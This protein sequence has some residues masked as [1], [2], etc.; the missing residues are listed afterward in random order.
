MGEETNEAVQ[1]DESIPV[2]PSQTFFDNIM[3]EKSEGEAEGSEGE[4]GATDQSTTTTP[5][6]FTLKHKRFENGERNFTKDQYNGYAQKGLDY[7]LKMH[8]IKGERKDLETKKT[9]IETKQKELADSYGEY[10][11]IDQYVRDNPDFQA[12]ITREWAKIQGQQTAL[13]PHEQKMQDTITALENRINERDK[14]E[15]DG[16]ESRATESLINSIQSFKEKNASF[17]W[18]AKNEFDKTLQ[19]RIEDHAVEHGFKSFDKAAKDMLFDDLMNNAKMQAKEKTGKEIQKQKKL[20]LGPIT[21][22]SQLKPAESAPG[23]RRSYQEVGRDA[24]KEMGLG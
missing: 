7:E 18:E 23:R 1:S 24:L 14:A 11:K 3:N 16:T 15:R 5:G 2:D 17:D 12:L 13:S 6:D 4:T 21:D 10:Q 8:E 19:D 20:G 22:T 9:E